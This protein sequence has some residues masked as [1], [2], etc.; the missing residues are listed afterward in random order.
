M[1]RLLCFF[2]SLLFVVSTVIAINISEREVSLSPFSNVQLID[3]V[4]QMPQEKAGAVLAYVHHASLFQHATQQNVEYVFLAILALF[5][6]A[7]ITFRHQLKKLLFSPWFIH[8]RTFSRFAVQGW[9][10]SNSQ[11]KT[12]SISPKSYLANSI[13]SAESL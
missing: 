9:Q 6:A 7:V 4:L 1:N 11:Y 10:S 8:K 5:L 12:L 3:T 2:I 13:V